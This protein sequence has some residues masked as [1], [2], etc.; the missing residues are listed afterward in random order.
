[1]IGNL[2]TFQDLCADAQIVDTSVVAGAKEGL[3]D[4]DSADFLC[5]NDIIDKVR[6][7]CNR[8]NLRQIKRILSRIDSIRIA[9]KDCLRLS[10]SLSQI[11]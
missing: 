8:L 1:M 9:L 7:C 5:R 3:I 10:A 6:A 4:A 2:V 11:L